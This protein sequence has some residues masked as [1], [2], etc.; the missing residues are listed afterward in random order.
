MSIASNLSLL[1]DAEGRVSITNNTVSGSTTT[2]AL[3]VAG[4]VGVVGNVNV[5]GTVA[6]RT[7]VVNG[8][9][10]STSSGFAVQNNGTAL[11]VGT[12]ATLNFG[13]G[14]SVSLSNGILTLQVPTQVA[15]VAGTTATFNWTI[16]GGGF[17]PNIGDKAVMQVPFGCIVTQATV[18]GNAVG[19]ALFYISTGTVAT[20]PSRTLIS[21]STVSLSSVQTL[22]ISTAS[23]TNTVLNAGQLIVANLQS[24]SGF[25]FLTLSL[26]VVK[27]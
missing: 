4:G 23:W 22:Q 27:T 12:A 18:I 6:A 21:G 14:T 2:G 17:V 7:L 15:G 16:D 8:F 9:Q 3:T 1:E 20:W 5:G 26:N 10:I 25:T 24:V 19:S 13:T 11:G